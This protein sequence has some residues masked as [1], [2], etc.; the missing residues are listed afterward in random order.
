MR[1]AKSDSSCNAIA[2]G[3]AYFTFGS[4]VDHQCRIRVK[5]D[6]FQGWRSN[7]QRCKNNLFTSQRFLS[8]NDTIKI[9]WCVQSHHLAVHQPQPNPEQMHLFS[10]WPWQSWVGTTSTITNSVFS[11]NPSKRRNV[12]NPSFH[13]SSPFVSA[14]KHLCILVSFVVSEQEVHGTIVT[15]FS[16]R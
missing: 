7:L 5:T 13:T 11:L 6:S 14:W 8:C 2:I 1:P 10:L 3:L 12:K 16:C 15:F 4:T 9:S